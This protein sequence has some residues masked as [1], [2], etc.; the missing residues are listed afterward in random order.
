MTTITLDHTFFT[1]ISNPPLPQRP[2]VTPSKRPDITPTSQNYWMTPPRPTVQPV[3][4]NFSTLR[5]VTESN[6]NEKINEFDFQCGV[7]DYRP[8]T[9][10]GLVVGGNFAHRGQFPW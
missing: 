9:S 4:P 7:P 3:Y 8:P 10:T 5:P 2:F 6:N 1:G